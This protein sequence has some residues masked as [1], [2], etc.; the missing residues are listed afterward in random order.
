MIS[1]IYRE[2][3]EKLRYYIYYVRPCEKGKIL[4]KG[5]G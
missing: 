1:V 2:Y 5:G 4:S 3:D